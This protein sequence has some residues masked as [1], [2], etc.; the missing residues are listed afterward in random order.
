[1]SVQHFKDFFEKSITAYSYHKVILDD[2]GIPCDYI[3]LAVNKK[4]ENTMNLSTSDIGGKR[5]TEIFNKEWPEADQL[6]IACLAALTDHKIVSIDLFNDSINKWF[7]IRIVPVNKH[8]FFCIFIDVTKEYLQ[9]GE[10]EGFLRTNLDMLCVVDKFGNFI[11]VNQEFENELGYSAKD[12]EGKRVLSLVHKDDLSKT[13]SAIRDLKKQLS[14]AGF[15]NRYRC[16]DGSYKYLE[17]H[18]QPQ[19]QYIYSSAR[20]MTKQIESEKEIKRNL[21]IKEK[22]LQLMQLNNITVEEFLNRS[23][24]YIIEFSGSKFGY[25]FLYDEKKAEFLLHSWSETVLQ[26]CKIKDIKRLYTLGNI[27]LWGEVV[28]QRKPVIINDYLSTLVKKNGVPKGHVKIKNFLSIP[29]Y[30]NSQIVAVVGVANKEIDYN[31]EDILNLELLMNTVWSQVERKKSEEEILYLSYHDQLTGLYNRHFFDDKIMEEMERADRDNETLTMIILDLDHFKNVNDTW[32]H[33][34]GDEVLKHIAD[35]T[36][37]LIRQSDVLI[38]L[39]GEEFIVLMPE[40]GK[41]GGFAAAEKI[42]TTFEKSPHPIASIITASFGVAQRENAESFKSWYRRADAALYRAKEDRNRVVMAEEKENLPFASLHL[43]WKREWESGNR[44]IDEQHQKLVELANGL[45]SMLL[46]DMEPRKVR[47]QLEM[48][49]KQV[50][51]HFNYEEQVQINIGY[52][53]Q[54]RHAGIH[55]SLGEKALK[56][57]DSYACGE[58]NAWAFFSFMLDDIIVGHMLVEDIR[59]FKYIEK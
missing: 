45:N 53:D 1:M 36:N 46:P 14:V 29:V 55:K 44:E 35:I 11:N 22:H 26:E 57:R 42:R 59:F 50:I 8:Y 24:E 31:E 39:G 47:A 5:H 15:I 52:P 23:L 40:T 58:L 54:L 21:N 37:G 9:K 51:Q 56:L 17:W 20:D 12:L 19:G 33:P 32:G 16:K 43:N 30:S 13:F 6:H 3:F 27:G 2:Q 4:Y 25:I 34:V 18:S 10:I 49:L 7:R 28:R 38:R 48:F 41:E